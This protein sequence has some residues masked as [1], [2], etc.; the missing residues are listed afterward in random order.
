MKR[1]A[2]AALFVVVPA[3][4]HAATKGPFL[5]DL[6]PTGVVIRVELDA[7]S[8]VRLDVGKRVAAGERAAFH[9]LRV[10][11]LEPSTSYDSAVTAGA[12]RATGR[13]TTAPDPTK[14]SP[15]F[16]FL[17]YGDNRTD[18]ASHAAVVRAI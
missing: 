6:G 11:G 2:L 14:P 5:Q 4:A 13:F 8:P 15:A 1:A 16:T 10:P 17:V 18:D 3:V 9:D 12:F 7:P